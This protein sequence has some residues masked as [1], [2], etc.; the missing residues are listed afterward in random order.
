GPRMDTCSPGRPSGFR[1]MSSGPVL[2][3]SSA[4][5]EAPELCASGPAAAIA[6]AAPKPAL[7]SRR[8]SGSANSSA[9]RVCPACCAITPLLRLPCPGALLEHGLHLSLGGID[10]ETVREPG[11]WV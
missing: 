8:R 2:V 3:T 10:R 6:T 7:R 4:T 11:H 9:R 1:G 5:G